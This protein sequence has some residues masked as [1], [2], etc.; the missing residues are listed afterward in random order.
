MGAAVVVARG[1][2]DIGL[3]AQQIT[4]DA[5]DFHTALDRGML[6]SAIDSYRGD[7]LPGF[8]VDGA[9]AF[10]A[11]LDETR[12]QL[13][14]RA[15][16]AAWALAE[17][18]EKSGEL[19]RAAASARRALDLVTDDESALRRLVALLDRVG[20]PSG[21]IRAYENFATR[22]RRDLEVE[23][24]PAS[25]QLIAVIRSRGLAL[26]GAGAQQTARMSHV[27]ASRTPRRASVLVT[28]FENL[29]GDATFDFIGRLVSTAVCQALSETRVVQVRSDGGPDA[30]NAAIEDEARLTISGSY[31]AVDAGWYVSATVH[32]RE[33]GRSVGHVA[34]ATAPRERPWEAAHELGQRI[35]GAVAAH[36][37]ARVASWAD[38]VVDPP[39]Y[40]AHQR[41]VLGME[42]HLRG[43]YRGAI[44]QFL[45]ASTP[46]SGFTIPLLWAIQASCN[47]DEYDQAAAIHAELAVRRTR[48]APA[49][50]LICDYYG[51]LLAGDRGAALRLVKRVAEMVPD[52]E[53][54]SQLGRDAITCNQPRLAVAALECMDPEVGWIPAWTP[55]WRRLTEAYHLLGEHMHERDAARR[56]RQQ[57]PEAVSTLLYLARASAALGDV[58]A[59]HTTLD[60]AAAL[61][62]DPFATAGDAMF[63][64]AQELRTHGHADGATAVMQRA[65]SWQRERCSRLPVAFADRM[66]LARMFYEIGS[67][68]EVSQ[69]VTELTCERGDDVDLIGFAGALGARTGNA[70]A[71]EDGLATLRRVTGSFRFGRHLIWAARIAALLG[72]H[73]DALN[74]LRGAFARGA[75]YGVDLHTD[76]DLQP[77]ANDPRF[78]ELLRPKG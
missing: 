71:A 4:C 23:P 10:N 24:S 66:L 21:A 1:A 51:V 56:G 38:A 32:S 73:D 65:I 48:L 59:V 62:S 39:S 13:R 45:A 55:H 40:A 44:T 74:H 61:A 42:L 27:D 49:E 26:N 14:H 35:A 47:L 3:D 20:D 63:V 9:G 76:I 34:P 2:D 6:D 50:Q 57:H 31:H 78:R 60:E 43:E 5:V 77:L 58:P 11:W 19:D 15:T 28:C 46:D 69:L 33:T 22:L 37:D 52:S 54:H 67:W 53:V 36:V 17:Q 7:L 72:K 12:I 16:R 18:H 75:P 64:A 30:D 29:T 70:S 68:S 41:H 8:V 25:Q